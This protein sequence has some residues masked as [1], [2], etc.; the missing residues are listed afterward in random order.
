MLFAGYPDWIRATG[1][2][3]LVFTTLAG[4]GKAL[5]FKISRDPEE[6]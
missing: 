3:G 2:P 6:G 5:R 4:I 1:A